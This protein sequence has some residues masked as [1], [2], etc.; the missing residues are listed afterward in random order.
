MS[1]NLLHGQGHTGSISPVFPQYFLPLAHLSIPQG[2]SQ[3]MLIHE[4]LCLSTLK[5]DR[6]KKPP[7]N[8]KPKTKNQTNPPSSV[9]LVLKG[10][11]G[12]GL[13]GGAPL[14]QFIRIAS[15]WAGGVSESR[16]SQNFPPWDPLTGFKITEYP[17]GLL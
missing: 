5:T 8:Q 7:K 2:N 1:P 16:A 14:W 10:Q 12:P 17:K 4:S 13:L 15:P 6:P 11:E 3:G 9:P